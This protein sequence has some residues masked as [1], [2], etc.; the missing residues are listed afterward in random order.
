MQLIPGAGHAQQACQ[1]RYPKVQ[2]AQYLGLVS[3]VVRDYDE[4]LAFYVE[5]LGFS[6]IEDTYQPAQDKR[7][8]VVSRPETPVGSPSYS[9]A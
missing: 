1:C 2:N 7:W 9:T 3:I 5:K 6:L 4:A 8:V